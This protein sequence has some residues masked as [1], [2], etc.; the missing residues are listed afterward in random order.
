MLNGIYSQNDILGLALNAYTV[1][2][3]VINHNITNSDT[4]NFKKKTVEFEAAFQAAINDARRTGVLDVS[5]VVP[6]IRMINE[7]FSYRIDGNN[8][9]IEVEMT[10]LYKNGIKYDTVANSVMHNYRKI[11]LVA[12]GR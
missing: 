5:K 10:E 12:T 2:N 9:D 4:P 11:N 3:D 7:N 1:R 8:V 6:K